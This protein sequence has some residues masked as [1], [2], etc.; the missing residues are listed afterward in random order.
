LPLLFAG[1]AGH[2]QYT[3]TSI[4][5]IHNGVHAVNATL[6]SRAS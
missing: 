2:A 5:D 3:P 6:K 4:A 1:A